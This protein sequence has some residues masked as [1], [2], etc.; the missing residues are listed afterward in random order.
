VIEALALPGQSF[1][2]GSWPLFKKAMNLKAFSRRV[3]R[4]FDLVLLWVGVI[5]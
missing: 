1:L 4:P 2:H 3:P 5:T